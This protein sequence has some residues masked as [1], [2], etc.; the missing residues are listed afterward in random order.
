MHYTLYPRP[1]L[2]A[3]PTNPPPEIFQWDPDEDKLVALGNGGVTPSGGGNSQ[4]SCSDIGID[5]AIRA[6]SSLSFAFA[7]A[8]KLYFEADIFRQN[9]SSGGVFYLGVHGKSQASWPAAPTTN[10]AVVLSVETTGSTAIYRILGGS[11]T[12][13]GDIAWTST[14]F[15]TARVRMALQVSTRKVWFGVG[16]SGAWV[17][18]DPATGSGGYAISGTEP[19]YLYG[20][21]ALSAGSGQDKQI[22]LSNTSDFVFPVTSGYAPAG[23]AL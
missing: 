9:T 11:S 19:L 16:A 21:L 1:Q 23:P 13:S 10:E 12:T 14:T 7:V 6:Q 3:A 22:R 5:G 18:G 8:D 17:S 15:G 2:P 20:D 4:L